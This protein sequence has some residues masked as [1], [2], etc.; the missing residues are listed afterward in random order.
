MGNNIRPLQ[1]DVRHVTLWETLL[2]KKASPTVLNFEHGVPLHWVGLSLRFIGCSRDEELC[3]LDFVS[4]HPFTKVID[5][6]Y[7]PGEAWMFDRIFKFA[8]PGL[9]SMYKTK[10]LTVKVITG[11]GAEEKQL[12]V[13]AWGLATAAESKRSA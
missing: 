7:V 1:G 6:G 5:H 3:L 12:K 8:G 4:V 9:K 11:D 2:C 13:V 10:K